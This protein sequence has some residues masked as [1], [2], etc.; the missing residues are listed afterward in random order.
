MDKY[1]I[2]RYN[3]IVR[4]TAAFMIYE[5][6]QQVPAHMSYVAVR[7]N[8]YVFEDIVAEHAE[9]LWTDPQCGEMRSIGQG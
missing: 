5:S 9:L 7:G 1:S 3:A 2:I 8:S 6:V 4:V